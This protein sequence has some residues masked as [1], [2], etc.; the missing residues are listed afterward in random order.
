M[1]LILHTG[2]LFLA[3]FDQPL[4]VIMLQVIQIRVVATFCNFDR[5]VPFVKFLVHFHGFFYSTLFQEDGFRQSELLIKDGQLGTN[6]IVL[7]RILQLQDE[8]YIQA[9]TVRTKGFETFKSAICSLISRRNRNLAISPSAAKHLRESSE[10][11]RWHCR[12]PFSNHQTALLQGNTTENLPHGVGFLR[13]F[14][15]FQE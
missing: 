2:L 10:S 4:E 5:L 11:E 6:S 15:S 8:R 12:I 7:I 9:K 14:H 13:R 1:S 3:G